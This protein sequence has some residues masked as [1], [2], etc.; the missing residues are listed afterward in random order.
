MSYHVIVADPAFELILEQARY[1]AIE[2]Q[3]PLNAARWLERVF[4]AADSLEQWPRRCNLA[5][6]DAR[7]P[8]EVRKLNVE[9]SLLLFTIVESTKT[10]WVIGFRH[11]RQEP[12]PNQLPE[13]PPE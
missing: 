12:A 4:D 8:Y 2:Q 5:P 3:A 9:G 13:S 7:R 10:V 11:G 6:E 1:I